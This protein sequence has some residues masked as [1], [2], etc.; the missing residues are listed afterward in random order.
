MRDDEEAVYELC[1]ELHEHKGVCDATYARA[2]SLF[3]ERGL[4][5]IVG[6]VGYF[7]TVSMLM[8]V[9]HTVPPATH[10]PMLV[11]FPP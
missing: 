11:P 8:N 5:D 2:R 7:T 1:A 9:A 4:I 3:G 10:V 6:I